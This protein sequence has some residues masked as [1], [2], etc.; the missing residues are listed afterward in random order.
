[1]AI[2]Y[3]KKCFFYRVGENGKSYCATNKIICTL[4]PLYI[5]KITNLDTKDHLILASHA[6]RADRAFII[7]I[8]SLLISIIL[9]LLKLNIL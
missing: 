8:I 5:M 9:L 6:Y 1:M 3:K 2:I 4:C 7:A